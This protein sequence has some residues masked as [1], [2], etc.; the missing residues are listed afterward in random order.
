[1]KIEQQEQLELDIVKEEIAKYATFS[2]GKKCIRNLEPNFDYLYVKRELKRTQEALDLVIRYGELPLGGVRD[3]EESVLAAMKDATLGVQELRY[4][5]DQGRV[6][7]RVYNYRKNSEIKADSV[8]EL[9][10]SFGNTLELSSAIEKCIS[11]NFEVVDHASHEL[12][13]IRKNINHLYHDINVE[14]QKFISRHSDQLIDSLS[15]MRSDRVCVLVKISEKNTV[16]GFIHGESASGQSAYV[17]PESLLIL[18]NRMQSLKSREADEINRILFELSQLVKV[19][20]DILLSNMDT[21]IILDAL[22]AKASWGKKHHGVVADLQEKGNRLYL[23]QARHPLIDELKVV[24]N[25]FEIKEPYHTLLITGSNTGGKS[26][27]LKTIGLFVSMSMCGMVIPCDEAIIPLYDDIFVD[28]GDSQSIVENLSTFSSHLSK[29]ADITKNAGKRSLVLLD[30]LGSGTDPKEGEAL[31]IAILE[32]L[33]EKECMVVATTHYSQLK[34]YG[35]RCDDVLLAC[36]EFD[37]EEM[38][39]TYR[40]L[41]GL[42]GQSNAFAIARR[43]HL[44]EQIIERANYY[45]H[46]NREDQDDL[47]EKLEAS[48]LAN[49]HRKDVLIMEQKEVENLKSEL[50][51]LK[52]RLHQRQEKMKED[53]KIQIAEAIEE[54]KNEAQTII[55]ELKRLSADVKPH[56][57][58][59][60]KT[61]LNQMGDQEEVEEVEQLETFHVGDYVQIVKLRHFG[62]ITSIKKDKAT[63][64]ANGLKVNTSLSDIA[65]AVAPVKKK[66]KSSYMKSSLKAFPMECNVIGMYVDEAIPVV[67]KYLDNAILA[68]MG[69]VRIIH[70]VGT[71]AL[72]RGVQG[73]LKKHPKVESFRFGGQGEGGLGASVVTL[74]VKGK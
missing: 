54:A 32:F 45:K 8:F 26:V 43:F 74:K 12:A 17:E 38:R 48:I 21:V 16:K 64:F 60:L 65:K 69:S 46:I 10:D 2:L 61:R 71:G 29:L 7:E 34:A 63:V 59:A 6:F 13:S 27:T 35:T 33:R 11:I 23:K 1:M 18:N 47:M 40:F 4:I 28:I 67:D 14:V 25:T 73:F 44:N 9:I 36:V 62:E 68:K 57:I 58:T 49:E 41:E 42:S 55:D 3:I 5:A 22:F 30:E 66:V 56:E 20:G 72:C 53:A 15:V 19:Q 37:L 50:S 52:V 39:P 24:A 51:Q 31:A 70:G